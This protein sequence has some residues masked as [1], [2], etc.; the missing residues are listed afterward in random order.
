MT[1]FTLER[2]RKSWARVEGATNVRCEPNWDRVM[3]AA[4]EADDMDLSYEDF[5]EGIHVV[6]ATTSDAARA[7]EDPEDIV[8]L[9][10]E[11]IR[12]GKLD[13][14]SALLCYLMALAGEG[15]G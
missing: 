8:Y 12:A 3:Q 9:Y 6:L 11:D 2:V 15:E 5:V 10:Q 7:A 14:E 4:R 13:R 1:K